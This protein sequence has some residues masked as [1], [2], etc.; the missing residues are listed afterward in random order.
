MKMCKL[1]ILCTLCL[2]FCNFQLISYYID[3]SQV[4]PVFLSLYYFHLVLCIP[5][6][7]YLFSTST[8]PPPSDRIRN[9]NHNRTRSQ[10]PCL[11]VCYSILAHPRRNWKVCSI[12]FFLWMLIII[13]ITIK[14]YVHTPCACRTHTDSNFTEPRCTHLSQPT[15]NKYQTDPYKQKFCTSQFCDFQAKPFL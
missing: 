10:S 11:L 12:W 4:L 15:T 13:K 1:F 9:H 8:P 7:L 3:A 14:L 5:F 2:T 6:G